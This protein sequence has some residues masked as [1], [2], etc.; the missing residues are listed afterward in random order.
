MF[1][2][3][4]R[5]RARAMAALAPRAR[6]APGDVSGPALIR[7]ERGTVSGLPP[8]RASSTGCSTGVL[9]ASPG[10]SRRA[11]AGRMIPC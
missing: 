3:F 2:S 6:P 4:T 8:M 9:A 10:R 1:A 7:S 5:N 11:A